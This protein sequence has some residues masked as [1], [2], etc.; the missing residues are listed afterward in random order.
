[1]KSEILLFMGFLGI[2]IPCMVF[3]PTVKAASIADNI[4]NND[5]NTSST[6]TSTSGEGASAVAVAGNDNGLILTAVPDKP[7]I[8]PGDS[9]TIHFKTTTTN[10]TALADS[11][12]Q[13]IIQDW[14]TGKHKMLLSGQTDDKGTLDITTNIGPHATNGQYFVGAS[15]NN[16]NSKSSVSTGF[17]VDNSNGKCSGSSCK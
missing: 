13:A 4:Q 7:T 5:N 6:S 15:A 17:A 9:Q 1:M 8:K 16:N 14:A 12:I 11:S 3:S 10:G 2:I